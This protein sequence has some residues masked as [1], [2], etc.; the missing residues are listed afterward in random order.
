MIWGVVYLICPICGDGIKYDGN[1]E[2]HT[3]QHKR[4]GII[5][6]HDCFVLAEL[7]YNAMILGT[8]ESLETTD[9]FKLHEA[10]K[11]VFGPG[12]CSC[13]RD[14]PGDNYTCTSHRFLYAY[15]KRLA[16]K[17]H[18]NPSEKLHVRNPQP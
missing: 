3:Y 6:S 9:V 18:E 1:R 10:L 5:C 8:D 7:K 4:F 12:G 16:E 17:K 13:I 14:L 2:L 11:D 15:A